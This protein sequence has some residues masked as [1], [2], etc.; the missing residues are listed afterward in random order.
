[1]FE[2]GDEVG[3]LEEVVLAAVGGGWTV[4]P[5]PLG[6]GVGTGVVFGVGEMELRM[7]SCSE[8]EEGGELEMSAHCYVFP[9]RWRCCLKENIKRRFNTTRTNIPELTITRTE[10][11]FQY[12]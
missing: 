8:E 7:R 6:V 3:V 11:F 10:V 9:F 2:E 1:M 5:H 12:S 4:L